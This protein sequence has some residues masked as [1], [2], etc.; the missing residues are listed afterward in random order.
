MAANTCSRA[1]EGERLEEVPGRQRVGFRAQEWGP[2]SGAAF[3]CR[4]D[5][6]VLEDL[7][8]G[9]GGDFDPEYQ[10]LAVYAPVAPAQILPNQAKH[11]GA[12]RAYRGVL[13]WLAP[14]APQLDAKRQSDAHVEAAAHASETRSVQ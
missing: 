9:R 12:D 3:G 11:Q 7:P 6:G 1:G 13:P 14:D 4:V 2:G 10:Q 5:S 8:H